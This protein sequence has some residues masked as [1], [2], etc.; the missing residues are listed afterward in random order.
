MLLCFVNIVVKGSLALYVRWLGIGVGVLPLRFSGS[1]EGT[2]VIY[3]VAL[4]MQPQRKHVDN[5]DARHRN[6]S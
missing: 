3:L 1:R 6:T 4:V 5:G 2:V